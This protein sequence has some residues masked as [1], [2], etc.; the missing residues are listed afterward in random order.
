MKKGLIQALA[1]SVVMTYICMGTAPGVLPDRGLTLTAQAASDALSSQQR[2]NAWYSQAIEHINNQNFESALLCLDGCAVYADPEN[3]ATL[4]ADIYLKRGYC[5][6]MLE[7]QED[8]LE[9]LDE[10]LRVD[11]ELESAILIRISILSDQERYEEAIEWMEKYISLTEDADMY[12]TLA[13]LYEVTGQTDKALESYRTYTEKTSG[14][15]TEAAYAMGV[16]RLERGYY[17]EALEEFAPCLEDENLGLSSAFNSGVCRM[18]L[19]EYEEAIALFDRCIEED[20]GIDGM[21]YYRGQCRMAL[22]TYE[23][24]I[25]DFAMSVEKEESVANDAL[26]A[27]ANYEMGNMAYTEAISDFTA[28][29]EREIEPGTSRI[30]RGICRLLS[31]EMENAMSDFTKCIDEDTNA[32]EARF[33]RSFVYLN[34]GDYQYALD[35]LNSC[36]E[37]GYDLAGSYQQRSQV[38]K[39]MGDTESYKA[40]LAEAQEQLLAAQEQPEAVTEAETQSGAEE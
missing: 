11:P 29:L 15:E 9:A 10:A 1:A 17:Q 30:N 20:A 5:Y 22:G 40:D 2:L 23:D 18:S 26:Y 3:N 14:S 31:G 21:Y 4:Y 28:C 36:I 16:Y 34:W 33:Y 12:Q 27:K 24:A 35:D 19:G 13:S 38:F 37:H 39:A 25:A 32:D 7:R 8:S 6:M